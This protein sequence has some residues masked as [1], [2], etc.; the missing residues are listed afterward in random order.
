M[1]LLTS[2]NAFP[3]WRSCTLRWPNLPHPIPYIVW[4]HIWPC[5]GSGRGDLQHIV[6][7]WIN[8]MWPRLEVCTVTRRGWLVAI[9]LFSSLT[10]YIIIIKLVCR[11]AQLLTLILCFQTICLDQHQV[12]QDSIFCVWINIR[13]RRIIYFCVVLLR[14]LCVFVLFRTYILKWLNMQTWQSEDTFELL[15]FMEKPQ[16]ANCFNHAI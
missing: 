15:R 8:I 14:L 6:A 11:C 3:A 7:P 10:I 9:C 13:W 1:W 4:Q 2:W 5:G 12:T 16:Q